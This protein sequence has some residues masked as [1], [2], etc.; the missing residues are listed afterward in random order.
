MTDNDGQLITILDDLRNQRKPV[1]RNRSERIF[2]HNLSRTTT[3]L[4][5]Q[6]QAFRLKLAKANG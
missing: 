4:D 1:E 3:L 2:D 6:L 5:S